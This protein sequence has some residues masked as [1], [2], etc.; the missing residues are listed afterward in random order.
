LKTS[1]LPHLWLCILFDLAGL[2]SYLLPVL[3]ETEDLIWAP[4]SGV[5]FYF[6]FGRRRFGL[7]GGIF[8]FIEEI[9]PGLDFIPTFT[10]AWFIRKRELQ[11]KSED[12]IGQ[13]FRSSLMKS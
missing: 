12:S 10:I 1:P 5:I 6:L 8:S 11:R 2:I 13:K 9:S 3:G 7:L 4:L